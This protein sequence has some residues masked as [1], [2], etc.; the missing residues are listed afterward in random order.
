MKKLYASLTALLLIA[1]GGVEQPAQP[2]VPE[3]GDGSVTGVTLSDEFV[4]LS[5]GKSYLVTATVLPENA[6][7]K[8]VLWST[9]NNQVATVKDGLITAVGDGKAT[10]TATTVDG[11]L[12]ATCRVEVNTIYVDRIDI[13]ENEILMVIGTD[14]QIEPVISPSNAENAAIGYEVTSGK[15]VV[16]VSQDGLVHAEKV[17]QAVVRVFAKDGHG[18]QAQ[19]RIGVQAEPIYPTA[20]VA[21]F[22][23][24]IVVGKTVE[25]KMSWTPATTNQ[26]GYTITSS[27]PEVVTAE[28]ISGLAFRVRALK[29]SD[30]Q[31]KLTFTSESDPSVKSVHIVYVHTGE[32]S[33]AWDCDWKT[34]YGTLDEGM[35]P[36]ES[37]SASASVTNLHDQEIIYRTDNPSVASVNSSTGKLTAVGEGETT[38]TAVSAANPTLKV[39]RTVKVW[40]APQEVYFPGGEHVFVKPGATVKVKAYVRDSRHAN[41]RQVLIVEDNAGDLKVTTASLSDDGSGKKCVFIT[42]ESRLSSR[43]STI[44]YPVKFRIPLVSGYLSTQAWFYSCQW[45]GDDVKPYDAIVVSSTGSLA[46]Y[47]SGFRGYSSDKKTAYW[48]NGSGPYT[49]SNQRNAAAFVYWVGTPGDSKSA[50]RKLNLPG[51]AKGNGAKVHGYAV[52]AADA[53]SNISDTERARFQNTANNIS[54][55]QSFK[56]ACPACTAGATGRF[57]Y[58]ITQGIVAYNTDR[59]PGY[60]VHPVQHIYRAGNADSHNAGGYGYYDESHP[61]KPENK[62]SS[63]WFLPAQAELLLMMGKDGDAQTSTAWLTHFNALFDAASGTRMQTHLSYWT[64]NQGTTESTALA[65]TGAGTVNSLTKTSG[66][67]CT[68][69]VLAF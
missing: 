59:G 7:N 27:L 21:F 56:N 46:V 47:D 62:Y 49:S 9:S 37:Y 42:L 55:R 8:K 36:G 30:Q 57:G 31:V 32:A 69:A 17:G 63:G 13:G 58:D 4:P 54:D 44:Q 5:I 29:A 14:Y 6:I 67:A 39:T 1:C 64:C 50:L 22:D 53:F 35:V 45:D 28:R 66:V 23:Q 3:D 48:A 12:T 26:T 24:E 10:I 51:I 34:S 11:M 60:T 19:L 16:T 15:D 68:R 65:V 20:M 61:L 52:A 2:S 18:A 38:L 43:T 41:T 33:I 40:S 25:G